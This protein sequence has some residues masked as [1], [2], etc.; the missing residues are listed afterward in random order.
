MIEMVLLLS[1][2]VLLSMVAPSKE[3]PTIGS[4]IAASS[5]RVD[6]PAFDQNVALPTGKF[7]EG[8]PSQ[9]TRR[10]ELARPTAIHATIFSMD[11]REEDPCG[12]GDTQLPA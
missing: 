2:A 10:I 7:Q 8:P 5:T 4:L 1:S 12:P 9:T 11:P 6:M 3:N